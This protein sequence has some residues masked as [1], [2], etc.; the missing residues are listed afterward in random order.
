MKVSQIQEIKS[1]RQLCILNFRY[2]VTL[3]KTDMKINTDS[4][5]H[6]ALVS[7]GVEEITNNY[8]K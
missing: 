2:P 8:D 1:L 5:S 4:L 3:A 7:V 6:I